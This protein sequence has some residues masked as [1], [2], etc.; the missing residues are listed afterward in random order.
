MFGIRVNFGFSQTRV[1][2]SKVLIQKCQPNGNPSTYVGR[3]TSKT[4]I[5]RLVK[6]SS[7]GVKVLKMTPVRTAFRCH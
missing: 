7:M 3:V 2:V 1:S 4:T 5:T 6:S